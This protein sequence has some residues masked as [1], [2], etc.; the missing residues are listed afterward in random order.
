MDTST[1]HK[2]ARMKNV[3]ALTVTVFALFFS[4][5]FAQSELQAGQKYV[6]GSSVKSTYFGISLKIPNGVTAAYNEQDGRQALAGAN[7]DGSLIFLMLFQ[8]GV[9]PQTYNNLLL[10]PLPLGEVNLQPTSAPSNLS[11]QTADLEKGI[12]GQT[13]VLGGAN[14][15]LLLIVFAV[16]G[17]EAQMTGLIQSFKA[18][19]KL[20]KSLAG[21]GEAKA[22]QDLTRFL[23]G[24]LLVRSA[25]TSNNSVNGLGSSSNESRMVLCSNQAFEYKSTSSVS[26][27]VPDSSLLDSSTNTSQ[28][29]WVV[30]YANQKGAILTLTDQSGIQRRMSLRVV[31]GNEFVRL[32]EAAWR[33]YKAEC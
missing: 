12:T 17:N 32:N 15:S 4:Q 1:S 28:G 26:I 27:S 31:G 9:S 11:V 29:R 5:G 16:Q 10:Q 6:A 22:I 7:A 3:I 20:G 19:V 23:S 2:E 24:K 18:S 8:H 13:T 33:V 25:G 14:S 21:S 30:E